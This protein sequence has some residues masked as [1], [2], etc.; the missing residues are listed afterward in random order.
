MRHARPQPFL[1]AAAL[2]VAGLGAAAC[3]SSSSPTSTTSHPA[4]SVSPASSTSTTV[5]V[6]NN[7]TYG[8]VLVNS[9]G[10]PLY[11]YG[12]DKGHG[13]K[14]TCTGSCLQQWPALVV[15]SGTTPTKGTGVTGT[16]SAV[17]Q[18][19]GT[20]QVTYNSMPLYTFVSDT[21]SGQV[22]GNGVMGFSVAK[23]SSSS[24]SPAATPTTKPSSPTTKPSS[25]TST[26]AS[27]STTATTMP[28]TTTTT[29]G[30]SGY[31]GGY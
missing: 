9:A 13:G 14:S 22:T 11:T 8:K 28:T 24:V 23:V 19:N 25:P 31:G 30:G 26:S 2:A 18:S 29:A 4:T 7:S 10:K 17:M 27:S 5:R 20:D 3:S 1:V 16:V 15:P 21:S 12:P 6:E